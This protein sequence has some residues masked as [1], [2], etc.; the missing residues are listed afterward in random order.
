MA[1]VK[2]AFLGGVQDASD[3]SGVT[4]ST[5]SAWARVAALSHTARKFALRRWRMGC[6][7]L[8]IEE[9]LKTD[10]RKPFVRAA[11]L[12]SACCPAPNLL[13]QCSGHAIS[14][15]SRNRTAAAALAARTR[16]T[17]LSPVVLADNHWRIGAASQG[18]IVCDERAACNFPGQGNFRVSCR[19]NAWL[20]ANR[21]S[22]WTV[23][24]P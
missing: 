4:R 21:N 24:K 14:H 15:C 11:I 8:G 16:G 13:P 7:W 19:R 3:C 12:A 17:L 2:T 9:I 20:L 22:S 6:W 23:S 10:W 5:V 18:V 1:G